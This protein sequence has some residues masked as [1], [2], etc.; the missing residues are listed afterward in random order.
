M[1]RP[2]PEAPPGGL[3][4]RV[5]PDAMFQPAVDPA[6]VQTE[7]RG[8]ASRALLLAEDRWLLVVGD[9]NARRLIDIKSGARIRD[10]RDAIRIRIRAWRIVQ[11]GLAT[12]YDTICGM[13]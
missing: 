3:S 1:F 13:R 10:A 4:V 9:G 12:S 6:H 11:K 8:S 5:L 2:A 7:G